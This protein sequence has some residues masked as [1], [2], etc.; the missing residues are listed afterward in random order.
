MVG[1]DAFP[2]PSSN[3]LTV[4]VLSEEVGLESSNALIANVA[5]GPAPAGAD[6]FIEDAILFADASKVAASALICA[7]C[8]WAAAAAAA[9]SAAACAAGSIST[10]GCALL[11]ALLAASMLMIDAA[12]LPIP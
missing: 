10:R 4:T 3:A 9:A 2:V 12:A 1:A 8:C 5:S 7:C 11:A 6:P